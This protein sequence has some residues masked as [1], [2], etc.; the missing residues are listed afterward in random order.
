MLSKNVNNKKCGP[1]LIFFNE[2]STTCNTI[3]K[4]LE[5]QGYSNVQNYAGSFKD[6]KANGGDIE[7]L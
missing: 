5:K 2:N 1:K 4:G 3:T 7:S 6:W